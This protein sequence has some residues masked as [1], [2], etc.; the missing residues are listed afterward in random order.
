[1]TLRIAHVMAGAA[2]GGAEAFY[3]RL[4]LAQH[5]AGEEVLAV[6]RQDAGRAARLRQGGLDPV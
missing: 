1:M 4:A 2:M 5:A 3:E 6:I